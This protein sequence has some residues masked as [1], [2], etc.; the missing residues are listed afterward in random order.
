MTSDELLERYF[1]LLPGGRLGLAVRSALEAAV[2]TVGA[3]EGSLLAHDEAADDLCFVMTVG[4]AESERT[5]L[6]QRVPL[7]QGITGLAAA[8][9]E[10]QVGAPVFKDVKQSERLSEGPEAVLAAPLLVGEELL[11]VI[12]AVSFV[13]GRRFGSRE[14]ELFE[15]TAQVIAALIETAAASSGGTA[16][17]A[18]YGSAARREEVVLERLRQILRRDPA[19]LD[20]VEALVT[21]IERLVSVGH[22]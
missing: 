10:V 5:L 8:K 11:G 2:A 12:T 20:A 7:G 22:L 17:P 14:A 3:E 4:N 19:A 18:A 15:R 16:V 13:D 9:G 21:A 1:G 6:A